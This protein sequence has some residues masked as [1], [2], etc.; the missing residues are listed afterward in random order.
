MGRLLEMKRKQIKA[1]AKVPSAESAAVKLEHALVHLRARELEPARALCLD[2]LAQNVRHAPALNLLGMVEFEAGNALGARRMLERALS[3]DVQNRLYLLNYGMILHA[4][5]ER[6]SA[7]VVYRRLLE[8]YPQDVSALNNFGSLRREE[9]QLEEAEALLETARELAPE[10]VAILGNLG[11]VFKEQGRMSEAR[12]AL[13]EALRLM[14]THLASLIN[15]GSV[16]RLEGRW[17]EARLL[18]QRALKLAPNSPEA[19][20]NLANLTADEGDFEKAVALHLQAIDLQPR[21]AESHGNLANTLLT[22]GRV[23]E[24]LRS[25]QQAL[26]LNPSS[27]EIAFNQAMALLVCGNFAAGWSSYEARLL[28]PGQRSRQLK[29]PLW[30]GEALGG[31]HLF[32]HAEQGLGD[33]LMAL[34]YLPLIEKD[35]GRVSLMLQDSLHSLAATLGGFDELLGMDAPIPAHDLHCPVM[36]LPR[37]C[38]TMQ[39]E[40][41]P[42]DVPYLHVPQEL[43]ERARKL[44][45][46]GG[47]LRVGLVWAGN[48]VHANDRR[49]SIPLELLRPLCAFEGVQFY[50]L[51]MGARAY[52]PERLGL[53]IE[54][55]PLTAEMANTAALIGELDL[56]ITVDTAVA[57]LAGAL[58]RRAWVMIAA[59]PD[60]RWFLGRSSSP[61]YPT[62][63]LFRQP[64][65]G[66]WGRVVEDLCLALDEL[67]HSR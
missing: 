47:K 66:D 52:E 12:A 2:V 59:S 14:P 38:G 50:S 19:L 4:S 62:L 51:Q 32:I 43:V 53:P 11:S 31:R 58:G 55:L 60:W 24:S 35:G 40:Q 17:A 39:L 5:G 9:G 29:A 22:M 26:A 16:E 34:R 61:W 48:P 1:G 21:R 65:T 67:L 36:S 37:A 63:R 64:E 8:L 44:A 46:P 27:S 23:E 10:A 33:S 54:P 57:H 45:W 49:R 3:V 13:E 30:R 41:I 28:R 42:G 56:V 18:Y 7:A 15:L 6:E 25:Y 20:S